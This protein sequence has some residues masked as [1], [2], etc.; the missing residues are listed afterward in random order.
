MLTPSEKEMAYHNLHKELENER[1]D[2]EEREASSAR[3]KDQAQSIKQSAVPSSS[4]NPLQMYV[5]GSEMPAADDSI[6][7]AQKKADFS[8]LDG[9]I[10]E[11]L[12]KKYNQEKRFVENP[13]I[14][15]D[16]IKTA[17]ANIKSV[18]SMYFGETKRND[19][20]FSFVQKQYPEELKILIAATGLRG[21][22]INDE[23]ILQDLRSKLITPNP[24]DW[25]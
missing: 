11:V 1:Q 3:Q 10:S 15:P 16:M 13:A 2:R 12:T 22:G 17:V 9:L 19:E 4:G 14:I 21:Q 23:E 6:S 25:V 20:D 7:L 18:R 8:F 24:L 5:P